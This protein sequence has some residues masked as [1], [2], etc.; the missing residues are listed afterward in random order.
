M[1]AIAYVHIL[2]APGTSLYD[3][4]MFGHVLAAMVWLGGWAML[5]ILATLALHQK[6]SGLT[7]A[8]CGHN[9]VH[10]PAAAHAS[11]HP[12][13]QAGLCVR[14]RRQPDAAA[15]AWHFPCTG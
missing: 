12:G 2:A 11:D 9:P 10:R 3:W 5:S 8:V 7:G 4:L 15:P 13:R 14:G 6:G 1:S